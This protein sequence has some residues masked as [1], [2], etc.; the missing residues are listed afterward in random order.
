MSVDW[1]NRFGRNYV[2]TATDQGRTNF[3]WGFATTALVEAMVRIEHNVWCVRSE[4]DLMKGLDWFAF[5]GGW[6]DPYAFDFLVNNGLADHDCFPFSDVD[7]PYVH[8]YSASSDRVGRTVRLPTRARVVAA[9]D[10]KQW[11]ENVGP[12][13]AAFDL[14]EDFDAFFWQGTGGVY[15]HVTGAARGIHVILIVGFD[16][17]QSCWIAKNSWGPGG[18]EQ[19]FF[20]IAYNQCGIDSTYAK[21]GLTGTNADP[22]SRR[23]AHAGGLIQAGNGAGNRN[24]ELVIRE[25]NYCRQYYYE[26][27]QA[28]WQ[29]LARFGDIIQAGDADVGAQPAMSQTTFNRNF[30]FVTLRSPGGTGGRLRHWTF[31]QRKGQWGCSTPLSTPTASSTLV[32]FGPA[33][34]DS[35]PGFVQSNRGTPGNFE[36]VVRTSGGTLAHWSRQNSAPWSQPPGT[37]FERARFGAGVTHSGPALVQSRFGLGDRSELG[38]GRLEVVCVLASGQMQHWSLDPGAASQWVPVAIFGSGVDSPPFMIEGNLGPT[39]RAM[40]AFELVVVVNQQVQHWRRLNSGAM[41]WNLISTFG[42]N[43][44][45]VL[46]LLQGS[47]GFDLEVVLRSTDGSLSHWFSDAPNP[48]WFF[49]RTL[50]P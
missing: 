23:R 44:A 30:E 36:V 6:H 12:L 1:R 46:G 15:T 18:G 24:F 28:A 37:W 41:G 14:F 32:G 38:Q 27:S 3:C 5:Q 20:R 48:G 33:D 16:D 7:A 50:P 39:Q 19:G 11:L 10:Q 13:V 17:A 25:G 43:V 4:G 49:W 35:T 31:L 45:E 9:A 42:A 47:Y 29:K 2:T 22:W 21:Y 8:P 40:G 34:A 26:F